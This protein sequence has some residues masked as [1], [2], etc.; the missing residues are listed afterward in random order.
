MKTMFIGFIFCVL[1]PCIGN[2]IDMKAPSVLSEQSKEKVLSLADK[3]PAFMDILLPEQSGVQV[4]TVSSLP[5]T[6]IRK[7]VSWIQKVVQ[8]RW[9]PADLGAE[10]VAAKDV[11]QW[12]KK[13]KKGV[14]FSERKGDFLLLNYNMPNHIIHIQESGASV[15]VRIDFLAH[16]AIAND[17]SGFIVKCLK[18]FLN[19]PAKAMDQLH[20]EVAESSPLY[21]VSFRSKPIISDWWESLTICTDGQFFFVSVP[22]MEAGRSPQARPGLP[23]KF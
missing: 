3:Q 1:F 21:S 16:Q 14:V 18:D 7:T 23:D 2:T 17:P 19:I 6:T 10:L 22:E 8:S 5:K 20:L 15:S 4:V 13:D 11:K 9:L 12:E